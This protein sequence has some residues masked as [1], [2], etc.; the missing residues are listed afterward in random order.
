MMDPARKEA[1]GGIIVRRDPPRPGEWDDWVLGDA[2]ATHA[3]LRGWS[4]VLAD[5]FRLAPITLTAR[6]RMGSLLGFLPMVR[7]RSAIFGDHLVSMP[8]LNHGGP[9][10]GPGIRTALLLEADRLAEVS[11]VDV[12]EIRTRSAEVTTLPEV[13]RKV[14]V[15]RLLPDTPHAL[16]ESGISAKV[17]NQVR[18]PLRAGLEVRFGNEYLEAFH[19]VFRRTLHRL[20]SPAL[21]FRFFAALRVHLGDHLRVGIVLHRGEPIAAGC[22]LRHRSTFELAWAGALREHASLAPNMLLYWS[23]LERSILEGERTFDFGRC[24][25]GTGSHRFKLQWGGET[26]S[27]PWLIRSR[28]G[29]TGAPDPRAGPWPILVRMWQRLP[30]PLVDAAGARLAPLIP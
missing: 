21:P 25:P 16:W 24:T 15:L 6:S 3:H 19:R 1:A 5:A 11:G 12:L 30:A 26:H 28:S 7:V 23:F 10:G 29:K 14:R 20:G 13:H 2:S 18:K 22:G 27:L 9:V 8:F 17:R 4:G